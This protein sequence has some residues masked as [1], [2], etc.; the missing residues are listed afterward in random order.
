M[1]AGKSD[2]KYCERAVDVVEVVEVVVTPHSN[3][4]IRRESRISMTFFGLKGCLEGGSLAARTVDGSEP[5]KSRIA[6]NNLLISSVDQRCFIREWGCKVGEERKAKRER[7][8]WE[9]IMEREGIE[10]KKSKKRE[11]REI[12]KK[13]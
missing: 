9:R 12:M 8:R 13:K 5:A 11:K 7:R 6:C 2:N 10:S 1:N 3:G 4:A